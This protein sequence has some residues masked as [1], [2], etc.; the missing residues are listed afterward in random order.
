MDI[1]HVKA[2]GNQGW[3]AIENPIPDRRKLAVPGFARPKQSSFEM[4]AELPENIL[5]AIVHELPSRQ[6]SMDLLL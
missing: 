2:A 6:V 3:P 4:S 1:I 5:D